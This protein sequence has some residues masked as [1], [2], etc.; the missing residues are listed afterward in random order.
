MENVQSPEKQ[1]KLK[2][3]TQTQKNKKNLEVDVLSWVVQ[4][5]RKTLT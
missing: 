1:R 2:T 5:K 4:T 3:R